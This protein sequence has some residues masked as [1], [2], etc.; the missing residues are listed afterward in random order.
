ME[1]QLISH[2]LT[3]DSPLS[4][5]K[6]TFNTPSRWEAKIA[7]IQSSYLDKH[8]SGDIR[9]F[10]G[11][12]EFLSSLAISKQFYSPDQSEYLNMLAFSALNLEQFCL[13]FN[14]PDVTEMFSN[15]IGNDII[16]SHQKFGRC[17]TNLQLTKD[18]WNA[19]KIRA[20]YETGKPLNTGNPALKISLQSDLGNLRI[21]L[22]VPPLSTLGPTLSV[23]RLP[24][25]AID[26]SQ[27]IA[28]EQI[29]KDIAD[30]LQ[31]ALH[32]REN[33]VIAGEPGSG[34]TTLANALLLESNKS[35]RLIVLEDAKEISLSTTEF[36]LLVQYNMPSV[37]SSNRYTQRANEI[38]RL[39]HRSPDYVFLGEIQNKEDTTV[40]FE[41][42]AAG[43]RG[44]ATTHAR[45]I[46]GLITRWE[47]SH[48]LP[49]DLM[50]SIDW[51]VIS[52]RSIIDGKIDR[53]VTGVYK[54][55]GGTFD[56]VYEA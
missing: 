56:A 55:N 16:I 51:V 9:L 37:G 31:T 30:I 44:I 41:G 46:S 38:A 12:I 23:R 10:T 6:V 17:K 42:F 54:Q 52:E 49:K 48:K 27:L 39:L 8:H 32:R 15:K 13:L 45:D 4:I 53:A 14:D 29:P 21:S 5:Y 19:L 11:T 2:H 3:S 1:T 40:A 50:R 35:W 7:E 36:P 47:F 22:Q 18:M 24:A 28:E 25:S 33:I 34:K 26:M 43:I 20:E